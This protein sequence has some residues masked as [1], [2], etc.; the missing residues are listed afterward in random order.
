MA[1]FANPGIGKIQFDYK[2]RCF[3]PIG[4]SMCTYEVGVDME[5]GNVIPDYL[6]IQKFLDGMNEQTFTLEDAAMCIKRELTK[7]VD[8]YCLMVSVHCSDAK[9]FPA[10][11]TTY[12]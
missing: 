1:H 12:I 9:H 11:V 3:C 8:P 4:Q 6:I 2:I 10:T 7:M 5:P